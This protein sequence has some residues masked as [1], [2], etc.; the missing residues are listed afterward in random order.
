MIRIARETVASLNHDEPVPRLSPMPQ[1]SA[2]AVYVESED[3]LV[4]P[5][6]I[7]STTEFRVKL[8]SEGRTPRS[9]AHVRVRDVVYSGG[10]SARHEE[11]MGPSGRSIRPAVGWADDQGRRSPRA[12]KYRA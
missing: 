5:S 8:T 6:R 12:S 7:A 1:I 9:G 10:G 3:L 2:L 4:D 11:K